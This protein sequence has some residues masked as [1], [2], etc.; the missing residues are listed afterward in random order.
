M[1]YDIHSVTSTSDVPDRQTEQYKYNQ[2]GQMWA[3][4]GSDWPQMGQTWDGL[5]QIRFQNIFAHRVK[6]LTESQK[7]SEI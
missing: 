3:Q 1:T 5:F 6:R 4:S 7:C 2:G